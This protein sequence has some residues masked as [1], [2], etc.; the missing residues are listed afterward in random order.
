MASMELPADKHV[1]NLIRKRI[2]E[3][4]ETPFTPQADLPFIVADC[5]KILRQHHQWIHFLPRIQPF[6]AVKCNPDP[7]LIRFMADLGLGFDCASP[8]EIQL[9][10][11]Q[12]VDPSRIIFSHPCKAVSALQMASSRGVM[13]AT[14]DNSDELDKIK[15]VSPSMHLLLRIYAQ[16]D[17]ARICLGKK[18]GAPPLATHSL[19]SK[20]R[21]LGLSVVGVSFHIGSAA[22]DP[23]AFAIAAR[24]A[25]RTFDQG[26]GMGFDM[27]ILDV[28]GGFQ[29]SN[30]DSMAP[31]LRLAIE[32]EFP[33]RHIRII[34]EPGRFYARSYY[35]LV[36]KVISRRNHSGGAGSAQVGM[37]YQNDGI[38]GCFMNR[39]IEGESYVPKLIPVDKGHGVPRGQGKH[40]YSI[41]GPTCDSFDCI[42][43]GA[44][45]HCEALV[46]D[47]LKYENMGGYTVACATSFNGFPN[48]YET[49]Y[50][51]PGLLL[52]K[53]A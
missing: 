3:L 10:L 27:T 4:E 8:S 7:H 49:F 12:G 2:A 38:Y 53:E 52:K 23:N 26:R 22:S 15:E 30:F 42:S 31:S 32:E 40:R 33:S 16:D 5:T 19:L 20:A 44:M 48:T 41:W 21:D 35:T 29:D 14:F 46:G 1:D 18:F 25:R 11:G 51:N 28:G 34:A 6:Y 47:W 37:L 17:T 39:I 13:L 45:L 9:V 50:V 24:D 36:C 43:D